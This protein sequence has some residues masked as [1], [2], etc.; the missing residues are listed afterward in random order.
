MFDNTLLLLTSIT[1]TAGCDFSPISYAG[2]L[3]LIVIFSIPMATV[4]IVRE[5]GDLYISPML[6]QEVGMLLDKRIETEPDVPVLF[7]HAIRRK[8]YHPLQ[9]KDVLRASRQHSS[10]TCTGA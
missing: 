3:A 9:R 5:A 4:A 10:A 1:I 7:T 8:K 6:R 2:T